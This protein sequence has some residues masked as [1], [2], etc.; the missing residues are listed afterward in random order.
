MIKPIFASHEHET[1]I[2]KYLKIVNDFV[3]DCSSKKKYETFLDVMDIILEYHNEYGNGVNK[4]NWHDYLMIIPV[5]VSVMVNGY[6]A[7]LETKRN[8]HK[9]NSYRFLLNEQLD[10]LIK[11]LQHIKP[12]SE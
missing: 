10:V 6:F 1:V 12:K 9:I 3:E 2:N 11:D 4:G 8:Q 7:G 5:N